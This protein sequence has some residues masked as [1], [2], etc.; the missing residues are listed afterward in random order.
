MEQKE[1]FAFF[2]GHHAVADQLG[3]WLA[4]ER[5]IHLRR[6]DVVVLGVGINGVTCRDSG[7]NLSG[8]HQ[9]AR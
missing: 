3:Q 1:S 4:R 5:S 8:K 2:P 7:L 6:R 9:K